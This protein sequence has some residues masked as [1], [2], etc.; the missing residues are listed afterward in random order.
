MSEMRECPHCKE[1]I[2]AKA[3]KCPH[4]QSDIIKKPSGCLIAFLIILSIFVI[5]RM[6]IVNSSINETS[7]NTNATS[8]NS[9]KNIQTTDTPQSK[10]PTQ[11]GKWR[12]S[13]YVDEFD[14]THYA[15]CVLEASNSIKGHFGGTTPILD[16][17]SKNQKTPEVIIQA[18]TTFRSNIMGDEKVRLKFD[19]EQPFSV[20]YGTA[21]DGSL[22]TLFL[23]ST[24]KILPKLNT[25]TTLAV[26]FPIVHESGERAIFD[27]KGYSEICTFSKKNK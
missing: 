22:D 17:R 10:S 11:I 15:N 12:F 16:V 26:E 21:S 8:T 3:T 7:T 19:N 27:L 5:I 2:N 24:S 9:S 18:N 13:E 23:K 4:C 6:I 1:Q 25:A 20:G 14:G